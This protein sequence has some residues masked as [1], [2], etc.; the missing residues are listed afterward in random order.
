MEG[1][2]Y[3]SKPVNS[4]GSFASIVYLPDANATVEFLVFER[5]AQTLSGNTTMEISPV[6]DISK[7]ANL[8]TASTTIALTPTGVLASFKRNFFGPAELSFG[9]DPAG[10]MTTLAMLPSGALDSSWASTG[11]MIR[12]VPMM[13]SLNLGWS[14]NGNLSRKG[15]LGAVTIE[16]GIDVAGVL[17]A[18]QYLQ[19][20]ITQAL[21]P[22][23]V[24]DLFR[25]NYIGYTEV[26]TSLSVQGNLRLKGG[27]FGNTNITTVTTGSLT[28]L[29]GVRIPFATTEQSMSI[30]GK[31][32]MLGR[33]SGNT[34]ITCSSTGTLSIGKRVGIPASVSTKS[35]SN[36]GTLRSN[37]RLHGTSTISLGLTGVMR[38][39]PTLTGSSSF[40][41]EPTGDISNNVMSKDL[42]SFTMKRKKTIREMKR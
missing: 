4:N 17:G 25:R 39:L 12:V 1:F 35:I 28:K 23:G 5:N 33:L 8:G 10:Q 11:S 40:G 26:T 18:V 9:L 38:T 27:L 41:F 20:D 36:T 3:N 30:S 34:G 7:V 13:G 37:V 31:L 19:G 21:N 14:F 29:T 6:G 2:P 24:L 22:A 32:K 16:K 15:Q 42:P